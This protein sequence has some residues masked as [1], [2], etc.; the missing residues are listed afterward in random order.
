M[1]V[2]QEGQAGPGQ[3]RDD[4]PGA[5]PANQ[6]GDRDETRAAAGQ[7]SAGSELHHHQ[8]QQIG[9]ADAAGIAG[10]EQAE[11]DVRQGAARADQPEQPL[12]LARMEDVVRHGPELDDDQ[13][14][15]R[16]HEDV[17][18]GIDPVAGVRLQER[19][20]GGA[21]R[22]AGGGRDR[23]E[24]AAGHLV[25]DARVA[26]GDGDD[27]G[28]GEDVEPG[29][30]AGGSVREVEGVAHRAPDHDGADRARR[31]CGHDRGAAFLP[32]PDA[33]SGLQ[34]SFQPAWHGLAAQ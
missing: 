25:G 11:D 3:H 4:P 34:C 22:R 10:D 21:D 16:F 14:P 31:V 32:R 17:E 23:V 13:G 33:Q 30:S 12:R 29:Q 5:A 26:P 28:G 15:H 8:P 27:R 9:C 6:R 24:R 2:S 19:P 1:A 20:E 7:E 18:R